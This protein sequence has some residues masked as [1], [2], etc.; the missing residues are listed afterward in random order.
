MF[1][2]TEANLLV[3]CAHP[4][5]WEHKFFLYAVECHTEA[6]PILVVGDGPGRTIE[7]RADD[8]TFEQETCDFPST[9]IAGFPNIMRL[10]N[11]LS[12]SL[13]PQS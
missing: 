6:H 5:G 12:V 3:L 10:F 11:S 9:Q 8:I 4:N 2:C 7:T 13:P 1:R